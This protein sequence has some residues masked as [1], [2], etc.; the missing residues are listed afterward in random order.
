MEVLAESKPPLEMFA[1]N[2]AEEIKK[3]SDQ[4]WLGDWIDSFVGAA[5]TPRDRDTKSSFNPNWI[6][7][8]P[9]FCENRKIYC[10][11]EQDAAGTYTEQWTYWDEQTGAQLSVPLND[12]D[13]QVTADWIKKSDFF[14]KMWPKLA[15]VPSSCYPA[16]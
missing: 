6:G 8:A 4:K 2:V 9:L 15:P 12:K 13:K 10:D 16:G 5:F 7:Y 3:G 11:M 1:V 14:N